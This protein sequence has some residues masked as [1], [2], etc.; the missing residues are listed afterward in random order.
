MNILVRNVIEG[1][2]KREEV[3]MKPDVGL[4]E[5]LLCGAR[6]PALQKLIRTHFRTAPQ[7]LMIAPAPALALFQKEC[8]LSSLFQKQNFSI[9]PRM[10]SLHITILIQ[11][12][13][14]FKV[15]RVQ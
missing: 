11:I 3:Q 5:F 6:T 7:F 15:S 4:L 9:Q 13:L 8:D 1:E 12:L 2:I 10:F 14:Y